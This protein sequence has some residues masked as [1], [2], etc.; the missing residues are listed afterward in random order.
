A[1]KW[2]YCLSISDWLYAVLFLCPKK[3]NPLQSRHYLRQHSAPGKAK[4]RKN[5]QP[6]SGR[7]CSK[8]SEREKSLPFRYTSE[9]KYRPDSPP[10][11]RHDMTRVSP[12]IRAKAWLCWRLKGQNK[13]KY[14]LSVTLSGGARS[15]THSVILLQ[16]TS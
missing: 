12:N 7:H 8:D 3:C 11:G 14:A 6:G 1:D 15:A 2:N 9:R 4:R 10:G 13:N 5:H 16:W